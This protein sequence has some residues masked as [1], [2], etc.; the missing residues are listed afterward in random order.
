MIVKILFQILTLRTMH[1]FSKEPHIP[2]KS[3]IVDLRSR[4]RIVFEMK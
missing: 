4:I 2:C 3:Q 1:I